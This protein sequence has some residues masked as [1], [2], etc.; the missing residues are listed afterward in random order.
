MDPKQQKKKQIIA[1]AAAV[2]AQKGFSQTI[3]ADIARQAGVGKGTI[4][5]YFD[6]KDDLFFAVYGWFMEVIMQT[7][8]V[9]VGDLAAPLPQR[10]SAMVQA[11]TE[12]FKHNREMFS[13]FL[14]F[15]AASA[16]G[17]HQE[18][19]RQALNNTYRESRTMFVELLAQGV[20]SGHFR[21][22]LDLPATA[23]GLVAGLDG[24]FLQCWLDP[25]LDSAG[26]AQ[27]FMQNLLRGITRP[28][29][30]DA[31]HD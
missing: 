25:E 12:V 18:R 7:A 10:M 6:S 3:I 24:I 1:A 21:P 31:S 20:A 5:E 4:Y 13:L 14:E 22:D 30:D 16:A 9:E 17:R 29:A 27:S 19:L 8:T 15:W 28:E 23:S 2:F 11:L 26:L